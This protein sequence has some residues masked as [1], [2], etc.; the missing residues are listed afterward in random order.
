MPAIDGKYRKYSTKI[1]RLAHLEPDERANKKE[2]K[3]IK[4]SQ[5]KKIAHMLEIG[6]NLHDAAAIARI[7]YGRL[8]RNIESDRHMERDVQEL[9]ADCKQHHLQKIYDGERGWQSSAWFLE[10]IYRKEFSLNMGDATEEEK[11][12]QIRKII[13]KS[14]V[15]PVPIDEHEAPSAN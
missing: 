7:S 14:G 1:P 12:I 4:M 15:R 13:R 9:M 11:A 8:V 10:R 5:W 3:P 6:G 2:P